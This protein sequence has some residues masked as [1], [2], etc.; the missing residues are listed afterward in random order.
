MILLPSNTNRTSEQIV[1]GIE[2]QEL[3][4]EVKGNS[5]IENFFKN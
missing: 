3:N 5:T 1:N 4:K 2:L